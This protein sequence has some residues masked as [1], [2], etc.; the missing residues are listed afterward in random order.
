MTTR[1][2]VLLIGFA[3][4]AA[5]LA[6]GLLTDPLRA[7]L[8]TPP[9]MGAT[10]R[11]EGDRAAEAMTRALSQENAADAQEAY[12]RAVDAYAAGY[13]LE[14]DIASLIALGHVHLAMDRIDPAR[15][16]FFE[17]ISRFPSHPDG[18]D[19]LGDVLAAFGDVRGAIENHQTSLWWLTQPGT[20]PT[21]VHATEV[22]L[23]RKLGASY[24]KLHSYTPTLEHYNAVLAAIPDDLAALLGVA[25]VHAERRSVDEAVEAYRR[26]V[27]AAADAEAELLVLS[28]IVALADEMPEGSPA[29][30][31]DALLESAERLIALGRIAEARSAV[32]RVADADPGY[33]ADDVAELRDSID[34]L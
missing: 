12:E 16:S 32:D 22:D 29:W 34:T 23:H 9:P 20:D 1:W 13:E 3:A 17:A 18:Y 11:D 33:R 6:W 31:L 7:N 15:R 27:V 25:R 14:G 8:K 2:P 24:A 21:T 19:G 28:E 26:A 4:V 30:G 5:I 10:L